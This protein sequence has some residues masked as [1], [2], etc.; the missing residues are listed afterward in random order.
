MPVIAEGE[1]VPIRLDR[2]AS[3]ARQA[4][5]NADVS[6]QYAA[7]FA[8]RYATRAARLGLDPYDLYRE[9]NVQIRQ[10][11]PESLRAA[12]PDALDAL[13]ATLKSQRPEPG[14]RALLGPSLM[15]FL[16]RR[17]AVRDLARAL[18]ERGID[19][20]KASAAEIRAA[21]EAA[22]A[23]EARAFGQPVEPAVT[24]RGDELGEHADHAALRDA[25]RA[26][27]AVCARWGRSNI[28]NW[29]RSGSAA[30]ARASYSTERP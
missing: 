17:E 22:R 30:K 19:W 28:R 27:S 10:E 21:I 8:A 9:E 11:L 20:R 14:D 26:A 18:N 3:Q 29:G 23:E 1:A 6:R 13:I 12:A 16:A 15:E 4:G 2:V 5:F 7:L 24:L 25:A